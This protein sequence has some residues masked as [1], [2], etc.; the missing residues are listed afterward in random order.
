MSLSIKKVEKSKRFVTLSPSRMAMA[1]PCSEE[2]EW[3]RHLVENNIYFLC[4]VYA[5]I[6]YPYGV[7][8]HDAST[9]RLKIE[10]IV[11]R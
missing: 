10:E 7:L 1:S 6:F 11:I 9:L 4:I 8:H 5:N 2:V 3:I